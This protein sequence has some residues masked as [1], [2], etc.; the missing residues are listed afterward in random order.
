MPILWAVFHDVAAALNELFFLGL[1]EIRVRIRVRVSVRF[2]IR[3]Q[4]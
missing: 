1:R 4:V 2:R 3:V